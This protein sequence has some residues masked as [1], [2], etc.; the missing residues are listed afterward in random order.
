[1][2]RDVTPLAAHLFQSRNDIFKGDDVLQENV[3]FTFEKSSEPKLQKILGGLYF[4]VSTSKEDLS[5]EDAQ[6]SRQVSFR[7]F[8]S[9]QA[10]RTLFSSANWRVG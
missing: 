2:L 5:V 6:I 4:S 10:R 7:H 9:T 1:M 3:I 8:L